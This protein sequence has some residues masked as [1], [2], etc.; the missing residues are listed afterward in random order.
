[1][2]PPDGFGDEVGFVDPADYM[3]LAVSAEELDNDSLFPYGPDD[4]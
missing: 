3:D 1:M 2:Y 4:E